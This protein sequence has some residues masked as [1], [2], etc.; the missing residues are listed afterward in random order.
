[1][2]QEI[3]HVNQNGTEHHFFFHPWRLITVI[4]YAIN[5]LYRY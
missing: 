4:V 3:T 5:L 1:M 2:K